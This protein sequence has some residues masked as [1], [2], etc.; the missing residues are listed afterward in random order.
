MN[1]RPSI[2]QRE[3]EVEEES[4][5]WSIGIYSGPTPFDLKPAPGAR[6]PVLAARDVSDRKAVFVADP[7]M[8]K[9]ENRWHMFFE[10]MNEE[11]EK[12]EIGWATSDDGLLWSYERIVLMEPFH[13]SYPYVFHHGGEYYMIPEAYESDSIRLY[14][15]DPFPTRWSLI[16]NV[17]DGAW[18][19]PSAFFYDGRW[20]MFATPAASRNDVLDLFHSTSLKGPWRAHEM[21]PIL[22]GDPQIAR[23]AGRV[24]TAGGNVIRFTQG[25]YP[26]YGMTVRAFEVSELTEST[27]EEKEVDR[28]PLLTKGGDAWNR[29]GMH[30]IDPHQVGGEWLACV[31][32]WRLEVLDCDRLLPIRRGVGANV[33]GI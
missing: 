32:G 8:I 12:G 28:T 23:P 30:H 25:C 33:A 1:S 31:D 4:T 6:N 14:R 2:E 5:I 7:F 24:I 26:S 11:R 13:L 22:N 16:G 19:D 20:W 17:M 10:V 21:N 18:V 9:A 27:Y 15:G 29:E 3:P